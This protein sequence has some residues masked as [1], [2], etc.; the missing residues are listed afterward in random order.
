MSFQ[1]LL[2]FEIEH[3]EIF[4]NKHYVRNARK[5]DSEKNTGKTSIFGIFLIRGTG[6]CVSYFAKLI[7][8]VIGDIYFHMVNI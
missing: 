5:G 6:F 7:G 3:F 2:V 1:L 4:T 8:N